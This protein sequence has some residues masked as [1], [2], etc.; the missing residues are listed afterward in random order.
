MHGL[1]RYRF[2]DVTVQINAH[3]HESNSCH[4]R[5][6]SVRCVTVVGMSILCFKRHYKDISVN[7]SAVR[8]T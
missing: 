4:C 5:L 3:L 7:H 1:H 6:E 2:C 8:A